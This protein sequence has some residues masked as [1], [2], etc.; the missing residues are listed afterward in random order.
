MFVIT[1][2]V[3]LLQVAGAARHRRVARVRAST[4]LDHLVAADDV[5]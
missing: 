1:A 5:T 3:M 2:R 4:K